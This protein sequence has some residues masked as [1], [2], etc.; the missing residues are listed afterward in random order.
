M[1]DCGLFNNQFQLIKPLTKLEVQMLSAH[2]KNCPFPEQLGKNLR[3]EGDDFATFSEEP[4]KRSTCPGIPS[5]T[6]ANRSV[7][8]LIK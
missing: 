2:L 4:A 7:H 1:E 3:Y 8:F 6:V 5:E